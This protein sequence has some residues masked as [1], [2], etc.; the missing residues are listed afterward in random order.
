M[1]SVTA[2]PSARV[3]SIGVQQ[4]SRVC[5]L[6]QHR[7]DLF[8]YIFLR[9]TIPKLPLAGNT[10][11]FLKRVSNNSQPCSQSTFLDAVYHIRDGLP[12][13]CPHEDTAHL[14]L[15]DAQAGAA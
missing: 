5:E 7:I 14:R 2:Y 12:L 13:E 6:L 9:R 15:F 11:F 10:Y 4:A 1:A 8:H 3:L